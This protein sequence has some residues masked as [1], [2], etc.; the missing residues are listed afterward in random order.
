MDY[1]VE[2]IKLS[3]EDGGGYIAIV[4]KLPGCI[5]D[6]N[7]PQEALE[8]V[9]DA[10]KCWIETAKEKGLPIPSPEEYKED[11]KD[12]ISYALGCRDNDL[13]KM[14]KQP[15]IVPPVISE[16]LNILESCEKRKTKT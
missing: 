1:K 11:Y 4:P 5:S 7:T 3:E 9:Q 13:S 6:G 12:L 15:Y 8:N 16:D 2:I 10:I 14:L